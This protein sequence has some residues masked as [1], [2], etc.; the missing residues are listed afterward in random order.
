MPG[1]AI[2]NA[3]GRAY[4]PGRNIAGYGE[5]IAGYEEDR[6]GGQYLKDLQ[7]TKPLPMWWRYSGKT[8]P[9][10]FQPNEP[11]QRAHLL[12]SPVP[13]PA[14][15]FVSP[16]TPSWLLGPNPK[17]PQPAPFPYK[18]PMAA[19]WNGDGMHTCPCP[20]NPNLQCD[21]LS[22]Q[23]PVELPPPVADAFLSDV[24]KDR[25]INARIQDL[26]QQLLA[27][28]LLEA[29]TGLVVGT[30]ASTGSN[31]LFPQNVLKAS[32][33]FMKGLPFA[34]LMVTVTWLGFSILMNSFKPM[35]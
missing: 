14:P 21:C 11:L 13:V 9:P 24:D 28:P 23:Y 2:D 4:V 29:L 33:P 15:P 3:Q 12:R 25:K 30:M 19:P 22:I 34:M 10:W 8:P 18:H 31:R 6:M 27:P 5:H 32:S 16:F 20:G 26:L 7:N 35:A 17:P 1:T